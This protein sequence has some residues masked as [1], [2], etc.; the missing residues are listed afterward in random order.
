M[1]PTKIVKPIFLAA[2][3]LAFAL[4]AG[5][6][7]AQSQDD[8]IAELRAQLLAMK[9][10]M[11][12][13]ET[14]LEATEAKATEAESKAETAEQTAVAVHQSI[15]A[16]PDA[17]GKNVAPIPMIEESWADRT[18]LGGYGEM[19][20]TLGDKEEIDFHRWVLFLN[21]QYTDRIKFV[22]ELELEHSLAGD[23][24]PGEV[25]LEQA[26]M[27][28]DLG[29]DFWLKTGIYLLPVGFLNETHEPNTFY[30]T[31]RN[32]I[33]S[34]IIPSTWW[35]GGIAVTKKFD[36]GLSFD[37]GV[38]SGLDVPTDGDNAYRIRSGR[39]KVAEALASDAAFTLRGQYNGIP[40][41]NLGSSVQ[42]QTDVSQGSPENNPAWLA[43]AHVEWR[44]GNFQL[45]ALGASW[46]IDGPTVEALGLDE[47]FGYYVEPSYRWST[48][49][50]DFGFF[51]RYG[52]FDAEKGE[53]DYIE[54]GLNY[55]PID[56]LV[57]KLDYRRVT[58]DAEE[59]LYNFGVGY[60]F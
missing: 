12:A 44:M 47:Q 23:G 19:H 7:A 16:M 15:G 8:E 34:E 31:E 35:E 56:S 37:L 27:E 21:H 32:V 40:G 2:I 5:P 51:G 46:F 10:Q 28:F 13:L 17:D 24:K 25:E 38:H 14:R 33:E 45:R 6:A 59:D 53:F 11:E 22:S 29:G 3:T 42:Y 26:Y 1:K 43:E 4:G 60:V 49:R 57:F 48:D 39:Q 30:G 36:S 20:L 54:T 52:H 50:G 18:T 55:W 58:G 9:T 41:F